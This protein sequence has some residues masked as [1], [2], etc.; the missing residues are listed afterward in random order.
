MIGQTISH[1][2]IIEKLGGGGMGVVYKAE[3]TR[4]DRFVALKFLPEDVAHDRQALERFRREAKSASALNHPNIC[5][6]YD[7]G[8][9]NGTAFIAMEYL[10]G[11]TLKHR[12]GGRPLEAELILSLAIEIA[13]ALDAAHAKGIVH[14]DIKPAN[15]FVTKGGHAKILDF[16]LAK[17]TPVLGK[18]EEGGVAAQSTVTLEER[19]T[20]PGAAVGTIAYMSPEQVRAKELDGRTDLF[21]FGAVLYEMATGTLPFRGE[22]SGLMFK[23]ILDRTP[24]SAV[25]LN[26]DLPLDLER[27][28]NKCLEKDRTLRYQHASDIRTDLQR[29]KRDTESGKSAA[30]RPERTPRLRFRTRTPIVIAAGVAILLAFA[31]YRYGRRDRPTSQSPTARAMLAVLPFEN[32]SGDTNED[33]FADGLTEEMIA[34]LGQLQ[35]TRLGVIARTSAMQY[36]NTKESAAQISHELGVNYL[37]EGSVRRAGPR[38]RITAQLI[39]AT[40]QTHLWAESYEKPLTDILSIQREIAERITR[41]LQ[42]ELLP[43]QTSSSPSPRFDPEAYGKYFLGLNEFRKGTREGG[44]K[45]IQYFQDAIAA[46]PED[47]RFYAALSEAYFAMSAY[48]SSPRDVMPR[49]KEAVQRSLE[50]DPHLANAH[51]LLGDVHLFFDWDWPA[52]EREYRQALEINPSLPEAQLGYANYLAT[53]GRFDE[54]IS[55]VHQAY[56]LDPISPAGRP[57]GLWIYFFSGH[58]HEAVE[59]CHKTIELEPEAGVPYAVLALSYAYLGQ[60]S[61]AVHAVDRAT[62]LVDSPT[63]LSTSASALARLGDKGRARQLLNKALAEASDRYVCRFNVAAG[64]AQLGESE[65]AFE[66]LEEAYLQRSD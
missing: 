8:E 19:L 64:Y 62:Q 25:R 52:A 32:L 14:R 5:T 1:Y 26:P 65:R 3:D 37:L 48:Y 20:S 15:I 29:L 35:P 58:L 53:L 22:S 16:G 30:V 39:Q 50:L 21:S 23:A 60:R 4:L 9:E 49:A 7:I 56:A 12:I 42:F 61:D 59:E 47:A 33:Y 38:V 63:V 6:I 31:A 36:K 44:K 13:E 41:S 40:D 55:R 28:V 66:S 18:V 51:V 10:D 11:M 43:A 54:A 27:I 45:A 46:D 34:Q 17:V 2:R 57:D 24:T